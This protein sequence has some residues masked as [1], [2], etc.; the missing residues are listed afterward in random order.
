[1]N[2]DYRNTYG[3]PYIP[4]IPP[5]PGL[6]SIPGLPDNRIYNLYIDSKPSRLFTGVTNII[7]NNGVTVFFIGNRKFS[8]THDYFSEEIVDEPQTEV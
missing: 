5:L 7:H 6:G 8:T 3:Y 4:K 1:M 2:G